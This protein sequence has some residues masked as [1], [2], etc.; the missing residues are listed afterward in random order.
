M[1]ATILNTK[2]VRDLTVKEFKQLVQKSIA[3]DIE[4]W[5]DTFEIMADAKFMAQIRKAE[6]ARLEGKRSAF[7][8][9]EKVK[10][11]VERRAL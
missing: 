1:R 3:E 2:K 4:A 11:D 8:P 9:W 5:R 6:K 7:I 10:R